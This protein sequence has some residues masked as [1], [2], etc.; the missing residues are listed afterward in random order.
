MNTCLLVLYDDV[1][2]HHRRKTGCSYI[3]SQQETTRFAFGTVLAVITVTSTVYEWRRTIINVI[4]STLLHI[5]ADT[6]GATVDIGTALR[7]RKELNHPNMR[8]A[9]LGWTN[10]FCRWMRRKKNKVTDEWE[11][12]IKM[13]EHIFFLK[14]WKCATIA[15]FSS[16][17]QCT[18][19]K[20]H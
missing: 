13:Q 10:F 14:P 16:C 4:V 1:K 12:V 8:K 7:F 19:R 3:C 20:Q 6:V 11:L 9:W 15:Y 18:Y 5:P 2:L 17:Y